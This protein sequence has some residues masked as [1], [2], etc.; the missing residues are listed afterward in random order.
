[1]S[2]S[3]SAEKPVEWMLRQTE[4]FAEY[5]EQDLQDKL[6]SLHSELGFLAG[7]IWESTV[8]LSPMHW[9]KAASNWRCNP[10]LFSVAEE[11]T[12]MDHDMVEISLGWFEQTHDSPDHLLKPSA[13]LTKKYSKLGCQQ[14]VTDFAKLSAFL[15]AILSLINP[16]QYRCGL[17]SIYKLSEISSLAEVAH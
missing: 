16:D 8:K 13:S 4:R 11:Y 12:G 17:Q 5:L 6:A 15:S 10:N 3:Q 2:D 7:I 1:M 9:P 14:W